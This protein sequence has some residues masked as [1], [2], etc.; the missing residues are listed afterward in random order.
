MGRKIAGVYAEGTDQC[1]EV[2]RLFLWGAC[3]STWFGVCAAKRLLRLAAVAVKFLQ[4]DIATLVEKDDFAGIRQL[5]GDL[6][7]RDA[8]SPATMVMVA[9]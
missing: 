1:P 4:Q 6:A 7:V 3:G 9:G 8:G 5:G 2:L